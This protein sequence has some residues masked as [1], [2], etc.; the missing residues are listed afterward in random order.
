MEQIQHTAEL[1]WDGKATLGEGPSWDHR[2]GLLLWVDIEGKRVHYYNPAAG[3]NRTIQ[4]DQMV[5]TAVPRAGGGLI[6]A[7]E[8]GL[9]TL[10]LKTERLTK[11]IEPEEGV[12]SN[13]FNDG[14]CDEAG[15]FW[16]GTM[17]MQDEE[18]TGALYCLETNG[19]LRKVVEGVTISNGLGWSTDGRTMYY[20]DTPTKRVVAYDYSSA[21]GAISNCRTVVRIPEDQGYPDGMTVDEEGMLWVAHW[22]GWQVSRWNPQTGEKIGFVRLPAARV[23]SCTF[24]GEHYDE[25]YITTARTGLTEEQLAEQPYA[26]GLFRI[27]PGVKGR[28]TFFYGG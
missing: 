27:K 25:L 17:N 23:T 5:G 14:K 3:S 12:E 2:S 15:R 19:T 6:L 7:L 9:H 1:V 16:V 26:G 10:D 8:H 11:L 20:I 18:P 22:E 21:S 28:P 4:L 13:R 24:G